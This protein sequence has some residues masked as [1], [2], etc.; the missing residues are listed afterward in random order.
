MSQTLKQLSSSQGDTE[1]VAV[2]IGAASSSE[3][4][5]QVDYLGG[6]WLVARAGS[7]LGEIH[8]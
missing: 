4:L 5:Q 8:S 2:F 3:L 6:A 1:Q 7:C